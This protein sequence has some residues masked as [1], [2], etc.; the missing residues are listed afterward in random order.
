MTAMNPYALVAVVLAGGESRRFGSDKLTADL[1]GRTVLDRSLDGLPTDATIVVVGPARPLT[2]SAQFVR[3]EPPGGGPAAGLVTGLRGALDRQPDL[4][5]TLPGDAPSGGRA[6]AVLAAQLEKQES[7][8]VVATDDTG[9]DQVLQLALRPPAARQLIERA[10][11]SGGHG[12][13]VRR[14]V[15]AL[16]PAPLRVELPDDLTRDIDTTIDLA[17]LRNPD[18]A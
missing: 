3:E 8:A 18:G 5:V 12:Q 9:R 2:R 7:E 4:I 16:D 10:G 15:N 11:P 6:A 1:D 13:S 14:L 17:H